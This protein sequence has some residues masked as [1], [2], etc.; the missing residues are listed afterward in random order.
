MSIN[1]GEALIK[2]IKFGVHPK[3]WLQFFLVDALFLGILGAA[4]LASLPMV[5]AGLTAMAMSPAAAMEYVGYFGGLIALAVVWGLAKLWVTGAIIHQSFKDKGIVESF[6]FSM[7]RYPQ[8]LVA[9]IIAMV[10]GLVVSWVPY[11]GFILAIIASLVF[12]FTQPGVIIKELGAFRAIVGSWEIFR[13]NPLKVFVVWLLIAIIS[14]VITLV[15]MVPALVIIVG[16]LFPL[17]ATGSTAAAAGAMLSVI[18]NPWGIVAGAI[19]ALLGISISTAFAQKA[20]VEYYL[21]I[22]KKFKVF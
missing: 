19:V 12:L 3:R 17:F 4:V 18:Q 22:K 20:T 13:K 11:I 2:G 9:S 8:F 7:R 10:I 1:W 21:Q 5:A 16:A 6:Q 14:T 15:F